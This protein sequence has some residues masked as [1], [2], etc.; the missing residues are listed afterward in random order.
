[1]RDFF[2]VVGLLTLITTVGTFTFMGIWCVIASAGQRRR[3]RK[4]QKQYTTWTPDDE[5]I[6]YAMWVQYED[7]RTTH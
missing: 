3:E 1:M 4:M 2:A 7:E 5:R 6:A